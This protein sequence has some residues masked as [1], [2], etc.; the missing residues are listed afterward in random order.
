MTPHYRY[1]SSQKKR[2]Q[3][4]N[5]SHC[6]GEYDAVVCGIV[7]LSVMR[8]DYSPGKMSNRT[9][10]LQC[11]PQWPGFTVCQVTVVIWLSRNVHVTE[12]SRV[13]IPKNLFNQMCE[14]KQKYSCLN[15]YCSTPTT[16]HCDLILVFGL[17]K[18]TNELLGFW[19][20]IERK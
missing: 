12:A 1:M 2:A 13:H 18:V 6:V 20:I 15:W 3:V 16:C 19:R 14:N 5:I 17:N 11:F 4:I 10:D 9:Q 8:Q 7:S